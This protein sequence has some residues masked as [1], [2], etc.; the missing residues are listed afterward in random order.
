MEINPA[1]RRQSGDMTNISSRGEDSEESSD[2]T[3][4]EDLEDDDMKSELDGEGVMPDDPRGDISP[5]TDLNWSS[6]DDELAEFMGDD[7]SGT[8][9]D[10]SFTSNNSRTSQTS[11]RRGHKRRFD[12]ATDE[13]ES[14]EE[15]TMAKKQRV[16]NSRTTSLKTV[17]TPNS[18]TESSLLTPGVTGDENDEIDQAVAQESDHSFE[19]DLEAEMQAAFDQEMEEEAAAAAG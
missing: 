12:D 6:I 16:A 14:E 7:E 17:K 1:D 3:E 8:E 18:T 9:S 13:D 19:D 4:S 15:S 11:S 10:T 5:T 2:Y